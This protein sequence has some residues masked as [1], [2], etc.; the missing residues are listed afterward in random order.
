MY[1]SWNI[2]VSMLTLMKQIPIK[3]PL[4]FF[5]SEKAILKIN[6][7]NKPEKIGKTFENEELI[8]PLIFY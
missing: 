3:I 5:E 7:K 2:D 8:A 6:Q 4:G 1:Y